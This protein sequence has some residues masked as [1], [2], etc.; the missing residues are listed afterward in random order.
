MAPLCASASGGESGQAPDRASGKEWLLSASSEQHGEIITL[1]SGP[2]QPKMFVLGTAAA[3][4]EILDR[5][6]SSSAGRP[7]LVTLQ[8][9]VSQNMRTLSM[10]VGSRWSRYRKAM[11]ETLAEGSARHYQ[12]VQEKEARIT[13]D[14]LARQPSSFAQQFQRMSASVIM[15]ITYDHPL[16]RMDDVWIVRLFDSIKNVA[17]F[18][19]A[20][21]YLDRL[22]MLVHLPVFLNPVKRRAL[23]IHAQELALFTDMYAT[24]RTRR[25]EGKAADSFASRLQERQ[26]RLGLSDAEAAYLSGALYFAG[27]DTTSA[28]LSAFVLAMVS[29]PKAQR[30]AQAE[31]D[32]VVGTER[33]PTFDDLPHLPILRATLSESMRWRPISPLGFPHRLTEDVPYKNYVLPKGSTVLANIWSI[34]HDPREYADPD[35]FNPDRFLENG[36]FRGTWFSPQRGH[37]GFGHGKRICPGLHVAERSLLIGAA[38][39]LWAF[40]MAGEVDTMAFA[41]RIPTAPLPFDA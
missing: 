12:P 26:A 36:A 19:I 41:N 13:V 38:S 32:A 34:H 21:T 9:V 31:L 20:R 35:V 17:P 25:D 27:S 11:A 10:D 4:H 24:V 5:H 33:M 8:E 28:A 14:A 22:P 2:L 16:S 6:S 1:S 39:L 30:R 37:A 29:N 7:R 18:F 23:E 15:T 3:A 40:T